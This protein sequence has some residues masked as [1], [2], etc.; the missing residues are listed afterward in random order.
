MIL[1]TS[2]LSAW[3]F[4]WVHMKCR[5][6]AAKRIEELWK[7]TSFTFTLSTTRY[8]TPQT[9]ISPSSASQLKSHLTVLNNNTD[10]KNKLLIGNY[11]PPFKIKCRLHSTCLP[12]GFIRVGSHRRSRHN[13]RMG[14][15]WAYS[16]FIFDSLTVIIKRTINNLNLILKAGERSPVLLK[17]RSKVTTSWR[18]SKMLPNYFDT[19]SVICIDGLHYDSR[20]TNPC[21]V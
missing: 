9:K 13:H 1:I 21:E 6:V 14:K 7:A 3:L 5:W 11:K 15:T 19:D 8:Q 16:I 12:A 10:L 17:A 20:S 2:V 4:I 18:C